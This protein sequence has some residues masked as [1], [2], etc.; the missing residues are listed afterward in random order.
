M[1]Q[2]ARLAGHTH[3]AVTDR[4]L[5]VDHETLANAVSVLNG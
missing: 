2:I 5:H 1:E 4:Y 3:I